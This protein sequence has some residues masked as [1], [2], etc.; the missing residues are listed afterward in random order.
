[1]SLNEVGI[2]H[3]VRVGINEQR[4]IGA[5]LLL[6]QLKYT[7]NANVGNFSVKLKVLTKLLMMHM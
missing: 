2:R 1:M 7:M 3:N 6:L 4:I 5:I